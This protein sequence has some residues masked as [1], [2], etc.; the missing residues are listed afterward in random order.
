MMGTYTELYGVVAEMQ[1]S[2]VLSADLIPSVLKA[3]NVRLSAVGS[4]GNTVASGSGEGQD[5]A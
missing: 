4:A 1:M 5:S 3:L 2:A